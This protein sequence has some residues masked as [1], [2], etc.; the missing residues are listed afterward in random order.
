MSIVDP[1]SEGVN[2]SR[3][4][5]CPACGQITNKPASLVASGSAH[6]ATYVD[7][8]GHQWIVSWRAVA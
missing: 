8:R 4:S 5:P 2:T 3:P 6:M 1:S 7:R